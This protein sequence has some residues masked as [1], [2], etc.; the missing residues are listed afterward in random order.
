MPAVCATSSASAICA[1]EIHQLIDRDRLAL[2]AVLQRRT[3]EIFHHDVLAIL[4]FANVV[5]GADVGMIERGRGPRFTPEPLQRL[6]VL[7]QF[8]R[9]ELQ[10]HPPPQAQVFRF[11][12]HTHAAAA[13]SLRDAVVRYGLSN[14]LEALVAGNVRLPGFGKSI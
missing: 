6:R 7:R 10:G 1:A 9:Q 8:I 12:H 11:V 4:V 5:D 14:H 3:V 2:D 13:Q